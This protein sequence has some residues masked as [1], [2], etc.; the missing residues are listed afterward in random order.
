MLVLILMEF[1][2]IITLLV[3]IAYKFT[4][5]LCFGAKQ[6]LTDRKLMILYSYK[7]MNLHHSP[8]LMFSMLLVKVVWLVHSR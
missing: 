1:R 4:T 7:Q 3:L 5:I 8:M 6:G 2:L